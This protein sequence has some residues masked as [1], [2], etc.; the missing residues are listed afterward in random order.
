MGIV[1]LNGS[2]YTEGS[3]G[4][5]NPVWLDN[6][7]FSFNDT[8][9]ID[10]RKPT[11]F[12]APELYDGIKDSQLPPD[13]RIVLGTPFGDR[14]H[15]GGV[16]SVRPISELPAETGQKEYILWERTCEYVSEKW[17]RFLTHGSF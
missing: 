16:R 11:L 15:L 13:G 12:V 2:P 7:K 5:L 9:L 17:H 1:H 6:F 14:I 8:P 3:D 4:Q 10:Y